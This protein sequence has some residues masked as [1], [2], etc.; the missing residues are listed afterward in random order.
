M[1][2]LLRGMYLLL[3][4]SAGVFIAHLGHPYVVTSRSELFFLLVKDA[5]AAMP[6]QLKPPPSSILDEQYVKIYG[7]VWRS[8]CNN[9]GDCEVLKQS[10]KFCSLDARYAFRFSGE[11][12]QDPKKKYL[13]RCAKDQWPCQGGELCGIDS[14]DRGCH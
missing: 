5:S 10:F 13:G 2:K 8:T 9:D 12:I 11:C 7:E 4:F 1:K 3:M 6:E 14:P